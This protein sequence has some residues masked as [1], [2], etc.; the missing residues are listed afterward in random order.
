[1]KINFKETTYLGSLFFVHPMIFLNYQFASIL[2]MN[3]KSSGRYL[4]RWTLEGQSSNS[5][6]MKEINSKRNEYGKNAVLK[7]SKET[8]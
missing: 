7:Q 6:H 3:H 8:P 2:L 5:P 1:M 4:I